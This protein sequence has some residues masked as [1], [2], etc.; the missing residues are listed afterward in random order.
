LQARGI[1]NDFNE[2]NYYGHCNGV[3]NLDASIFIALTSRQSCPNKHCGY[4]N[5][6]GV[7]EGLR[8]LVKKFK[9]DCSYV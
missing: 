5:K 3:R 8:R 6:F 7:L 4:Y 2:D 1:K 9:N